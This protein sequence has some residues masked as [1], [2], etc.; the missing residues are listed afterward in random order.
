MTTT[1]VIEAIEKDL[2]RLSTAFADKTT[3]SFST[4]ASV[5]RDLAMP[6][7]LHAMPSILYVQDHTHA[8]FDGCIKLAVTSDDIVVIIGY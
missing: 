8:V 7:V 3:H 1:F 4:F 2:Q 5:W 6:L